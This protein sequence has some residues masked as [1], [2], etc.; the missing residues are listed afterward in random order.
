M[1]R[2]KYIFRQYWRTLSDGTVKS[3]V[4]TTRVM[5]NATRAARKYW[6]HYDT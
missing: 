6:I 4:Y 1:V 2:A 3:G 5:L